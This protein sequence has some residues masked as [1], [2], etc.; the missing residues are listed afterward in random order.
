MTENQKFVYG[1]VNCIPLG[2][3]ASYGQINQIIQVI[4]GKNLTPRVVGF[5]LNSL[6][7]DMYSEVMWQRVV[8]KDGSFP[9]LKLSF[10]GNLQIQLL[11]NERVI[12]TENQI[13]MAKF[14]V[15][16]NVLLEL[17]KNQLT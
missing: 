16:D 13:D 17:Y 1:I 2:K 12:I 8:G 10:R 3:V 9:L 14:C 4:H 6:P 5:I 15:E 7:K 11:T